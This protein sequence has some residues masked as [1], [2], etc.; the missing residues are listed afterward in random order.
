MAAGGRVQKMPT[1]GKLE[2]ANMG[3]PRLWHRQRGHAPG[4]AMSRGLGD[5][6]GKACGLSAQAATLDMELTEDGA[7]RTAQERP[8]V[9]SV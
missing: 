7:G 4:L 8:H 1:V 2:P 6:L 5:S 9:T 3:P